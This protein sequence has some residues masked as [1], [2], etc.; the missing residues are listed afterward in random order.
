[1]LS[2]EIDEALASEVERLRPLVDEYITADRVRAYL[3]AISDV[4]APST[5]ASALRA[6]I[7]KQLLAADSA[8]THPRLHFKSNFERTGSTVI[9]TGSE[10]SAKP[11][12][13]FA[14]LDTIS[15]LIQPRRGERYPLVPFGYHMV[16]DGERAALVY[17]FELEERRYRAVSTGKIFT[18]AEVPYFRP[19]VPNVDLRPGDRVVFR[20]PYREDRTSGDFTAHIDNA[21]AVAA[22]AVAAPVIARV[23]VD[24]LLAFPDEEEGP[25]GSA[26]RLLDA[27]A[28][29]SSTFSALPNW[30][31]WETC[32]SRGETSTP[33][34]EGESRTPFVWAPAPYSPSSRA[35]AE[36][37]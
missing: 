30:R 17:R 5:A 1:V 33:T 3:R 22:L 23:G 13:Y 7:L 15:Y 28:A 32:S 31:S 9:L 20:A 16:R 10:S 19:D 2:V 36:A 6:P 8:L 35:W 14:H 26:T 29:A 21:G 37:P 12:W 34:R 4:P 25:H 24:A 27:E 11:L 18:E